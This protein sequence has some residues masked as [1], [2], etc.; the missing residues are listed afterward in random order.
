MKS[1]NKDRGKVYLVGAGPG[2]ADLITV[3]GAEVL[4][5]ADRLDLIP[6]YRDGAYI[7]NMEKYLLKHVGDS[8]KKGEEI[9]R[10]R[11]FFG[12]MKKQCYS[13]C[14]GTIEHVSDVSGQV[15]IRHPPV[16]VE[17]N[18]YIT[19]VVIHVIK[20]EGA[21]IETPAVFI[22][23]IFGVGGETHGDLLVVAKSPD[24]VLTAEQIRAEYSGKILVAG[25]LVTSDALQKAAE[26]G[27]KGLVVGGIDEENL[28][29]FMGY[30]IGVAITGNEELGL[31]LIVT[32]GFGK[33]NM[34]EKTYELLKKFDGRLTCINGATQIRAGVMRPEI[35]IP[36]DDVKMS[37]LQE[38]GAEVYMKGMKPGMPVRIISEPYFGTLGNI[39]S[40]P[41]ELTRIDTESDVRVLNV[42]LDDGRRVRVPRANVEIVEE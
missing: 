23:G 33:M 42:I 3:R 35:I 18:A 32:E 37:S 26:I 12:L 16:P 21:V 17:V 31:T 39:S 15:L 5:I 2:R 28:R 9:A 41:V 14:D 27:V 6:V 29:S 40:L 20:E 8:V 1:L 10:F 30:E 7:Y 24:E 25:S 11:A 13:P 4:K 19:G 22:Q 36:R 34:S 38:T